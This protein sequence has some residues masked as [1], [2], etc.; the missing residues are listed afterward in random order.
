MTNRLV[1]S[2][3]VAKTPVRSQ[4]PA[5]IPHCHLVLEHRSL[6]SEADLQRQ[7]YCRIQV[8]VS[9]EGSQIYTQ[10]LVEGMQVEVSGFIA[11]QTSRNGL[12]KI[13]LHA[14]NIKEI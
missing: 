4:S 3:S 14:D 6:Q 9:G 1:L 11:Y 7:V 8:V 2:G 5:G 10:R 12:N 13:I